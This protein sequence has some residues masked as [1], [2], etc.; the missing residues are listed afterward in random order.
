MNTQVERLKKA[1]E[2]RPYTGME[3]ITDLGI[4]NYKGRICDLR[5]QG[6]VIDTEMIK[7]TNRWGEKC[8][9]ARYAMRPTFKYELVA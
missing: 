4:L 3:I 1:L 5:Q 7:V 9:V 8:R 2:V 6:Y